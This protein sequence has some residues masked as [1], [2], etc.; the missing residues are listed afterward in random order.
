[1]VLRRKAS[2]DKEKYA[3]ADGLHD[4]RKFVVAVADVRRR[5][6][7]HVSLFTSPF[8][9]TKCEQK[10]KKILDKNKKK[11]HFTWLSPS[12]LLPSECP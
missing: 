10:T 8:F 4:G 7:S 5:K 9:N 6:F 2:E 3:V 1:M 12:P 11:L